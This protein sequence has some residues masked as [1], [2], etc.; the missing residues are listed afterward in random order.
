[1]GRLVSGAPIFFREL[2]SGERYAKDKGPGG[3]QCRDALIE[4]SA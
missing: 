2:F 4:E 1:M 3:Q